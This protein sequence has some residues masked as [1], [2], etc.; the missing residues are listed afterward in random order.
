MLIQIGGCVMVRDGQ[1]RSGK[2]IGGKAR[3]LVAG[4]FNMMDSQVQKRR[5]G[6]ETKT[7]K[8]IRRGAVKRSRRNNGRNTGGNS[9]NDGAGVA[10][11]WKNKRG[12]L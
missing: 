7:C 10:A 11:A 8:G 9:G 6:I 3:Y 12:I 2:L 1:V 5:E 4:F